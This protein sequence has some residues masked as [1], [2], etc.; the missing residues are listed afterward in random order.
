MTAFHEVQFP[1]EIS[2]GSNGG[3][4]RRTQV[5]ALRSGFEQRNQAW[6]HSRRSYDAG[7]G[8]RNVDLL[9]ATLTFWEARSGRLY[10]FRWKDWADYKSCLP[11]STPA[12]TDQAIGTGTGALLTFQLLKNYTDAGGGYSRPIT[13]PVTGTVKIGLNGVNQAS[14]WSV[15][16]VTGIVTFVSAPANTVAVTAGYEFDVPVRFDEDELRISIEGFQAGAVPSIK[17]MEIRV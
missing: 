15:N 11:R 2:F 9:A 10:G 13:K 4:S 8:I 16:T 6:L 1:P 7:Q 12:H 5:I 3:P 17:I 14:G